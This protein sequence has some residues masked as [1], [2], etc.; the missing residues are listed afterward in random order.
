MGDA[1]VLALG[2]RG[3]QEDAEHRADESPCAHADKH[4][5]LEQSHHQAAARA[6]TAHAGGAAAHVQVLDDDVPAGFEAPAGQVLQRAS[7]SFSIRHEPLVYI[8]E[9]LFARESEAIERLQRS[10]GHVDGRLVAGTEG[11]RRLPSCLVYTHPG[12]P[13]ARP[14]PRG[15][16]LYRAMSSPYTT[17]PLFLACALSHDV[18]GRRRWRLSFGAHC[19]CRPTRIPT[20]P[21]PGPCWPSSSPPIAVV[22][23]H[24]RPHAPASLSPLNLLE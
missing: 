2:G 23:A 6:A 12:L 3:G 24:L 7:S 17:A 21:V 10:P 18:D 16:F 9:L 22:M 1:L 15:L 13:R 20:L 11:P 5:A 4:G 8:E 19:A 14:H